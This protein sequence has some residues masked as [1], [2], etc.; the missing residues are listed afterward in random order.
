MPRHRRYIH[1]VRNVTNPD[2]MFIRHSFKQEIAAHYTELQIHTVHILLFTVQH[3]NCYVFFFPDCKLIMSMCTVH[4]QQCKCVHDSVG[5]CTWLSVCAWQWAHV[6]N[7]EHVYMT[8]RIWQWAYVHQCDHVYTAVWACVHDWVC[9]CTWV[10][11]Y[12]WQ[13]SSGFKSC[14]G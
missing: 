10:W 1:R 4:D 12:T 14:S 3:I 7:S 11:M 5:L 6:L 2:V 13:C 9:V 8:V